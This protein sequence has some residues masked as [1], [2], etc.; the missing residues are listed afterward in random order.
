MW[1]AYSDGACAPSN[2][3]PCA[4][5]IVV[6]APEGQRVECGGFTGTGTNNIGELTGAIE[7]LRRTPEGAEV[8]LVSDS[9]YVLNG[10]STWSIGWERRGWRT[11]SGEPVK[12]RD[13]WIALMAECRKRR[14]SVQW[15]RGHQGHPENERCDELA[16]EAIRQALARAPGIGGG[17][18]PA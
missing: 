6:V 1:Y 7:A 15:V 2:P 12:N 4:W 16:N 5:G 18:H 3:G 11:A 8:Q 13:L 17:R 14:V 9:Q 10:V